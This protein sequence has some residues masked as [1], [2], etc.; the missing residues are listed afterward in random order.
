M[1]A[2]NR[3]FGQ[4]GHGRSFFDDLFFELRPAMMM[5]TRQRKEGNP[6]RGFSSYKSAKVVTSL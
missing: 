4:S 3:E 5:A 6:G 2:G 1:A